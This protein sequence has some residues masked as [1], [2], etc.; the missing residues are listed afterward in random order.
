M[1]AGSYKSAIPFPANSTFPSF[2]SVAVPLG[3]REEITKGV[4][5]AVTVR[6]VE[7]LTET[8]VA[9]IVELPPPALVARPVALIVATPKFEEFQ[10]TELVR[11]R[12]PPSL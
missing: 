4:N 6:I 8:K 3:C 2:N 11:S 7:P 12:V 1:V 9:V 5:G 10:V